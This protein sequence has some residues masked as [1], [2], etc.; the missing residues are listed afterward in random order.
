MNGMKE[1]YRR[2]PEM[3]DQVYKACIGADL[4]LYILLSGFAHHAAHAV[5][6]TVAITAW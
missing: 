1:V 6:Q 5:I 3:M 4:V 2:N